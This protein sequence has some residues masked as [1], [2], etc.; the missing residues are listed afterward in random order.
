MGETNGVPHIRVPTF[1]SVK[2]ALENV[3]LITL[4]YSGFW[5]L[6]EACV[7][8]YKTEAIASMT[9]FTEKLLVRVPIVSGGKYSVY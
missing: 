7:T 2:R 4:Y 8:L 3:L 6:I 5:L 1:I 9:N